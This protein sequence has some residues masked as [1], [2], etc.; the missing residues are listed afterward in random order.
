VKPIAVSTCILFALLFCGALFAANT[1]DPTVAVNAKANLAAT[2]IAFTKNMGQWPDSILFRADIGTAIMWVVGDG[3]YYQFTKRIPRP[4]SS[5][6]ALEMG[7]GPRQ[8]DPMDRLHQEPD[9]IETTMIKAEFVGANPD[10]V[11]TG[12][13]EREYKCNYFIGNDPAKWRTDVPNYSGITF[14]ELYPGVEVEIIQRDGRLECQM[15]AVSPANLAQVKTKYLGAEMVTC[16]TESTVS[17]RTI[18]GEKRFAD[19]LLGESTESLGFKTGS[20][21]VA[22]D[23]VSLVYSTYLGG[24]DVDEGKGIDVDG[25]GNAYVIGRVLSTDFPSQNS[26]DSSYNGGS[27][28]LI[29]KLSATGDKMVFCTYLGGSSYEWGYGIAADGSGNVFVTG[30][31]E[32]TDF[33]TLNP[34]DAS[35]NGSDDVFVAKLSSAGDSLLYSTYLGGS[36]SD[37]CLDI[38]ADGSGNAYVTGYTLSADFPILIPYDNSYNGSDDVFVAKL[39]PSG[40]SLLY[41]TYLGGLDGDFGMA[42]AVDWN[43]NAYVAGWTFS[44]D[45]P[46]QNPF[47]ASP[48]GQQ[49]VF[50]LKLSVRG[51]SLI[52]STYLGGSLKDQCNGLALDSSGCAYVTG[53]TRSTDFPTQNPFDA[54]HDGDYDGFVTKLSAAGNSI[55]YSTYLGGSSYDRVNGIAVDGSGCAYVIGYTFSGDFPIQNPYIPNPSGAEDVFITKLSSV[56]DSLIY[57][58]YFGGSGGDFGVD[59]AVDRSNNAYVTGNTNSGD[60]PTQNPFDASHNGNDDVFVFK[61]APPVCC[62]GTRG[63]VD[64]DASE[65]V[66]ISDLSAMVDYLFFSGALS[67]CA[68]ENDVDVS[69]SVDISDLQVL[70]DFLFFGAS[71]PSCP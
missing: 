53:L 59:I 21:Q 26:Y 40:S 57:S 31:T 68:T 61:L 27:D 45:F 17:V 70:V 28:V 48:N 32:S 55:A 41:S 67:T 30:F 43:N 5:E 37:V 34:Y 36:S 10:V 46:T 38:A 44:T 66:D 69:G 62:V 18:V 24:S 47:D 22:S 13:E 6:E 15:T 3:I 23:E 64:G 7:L 9:S 20:Q 35:H 71:L 16:E 19:V 8:I 42:V 51:D 4:Q 12:L 60:F 2:P 29:S 63:N 52:Y 25:S 11:V 39:S 1:V 65:I 50:V 54:I 56:G 49:D 58:T 33:P 14:V